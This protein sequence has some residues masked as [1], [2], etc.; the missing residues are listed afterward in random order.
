MV[1]Y[2]Y[3]IAFAALLV[4]AQA[5]WKSGVGVHKELFEDRLSFSGVLSFVFSPHVI[6]GGFLYIVATGLYF[7]MLSKYEFS[8]IQALAIPLSL[9]FSLA[10]ATVFFNETIS[11]ISMVG[12][13]FI[14]IGILIFSLNQ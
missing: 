14:I 2:L 7:Y 1:K 8:F 11:L 3:C 6:A 12:V 9:I 10:V 13:L 5:T 4:T